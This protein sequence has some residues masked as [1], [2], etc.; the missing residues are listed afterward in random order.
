MRRFLF[1]IAFLVFGLPVGTQLLGSGASLLLAQTS[2]GANTS[3][4]KTPPF[5]PQDDP[6]PG[7][8][9]SLNELAASFEKGRRPLASEMTGNWVEIGNIIDRPVDVPRRLNCTGVTQR[10]KLDFVLVASGY[11]LE[12]H[13]VGMAG[14]QTERM[15]PDNEGSVEFREVYFGGEGTLEDYHCR[16]TRRETLV[17]LIGTFQGVEFKRMS[18]ETNQIFEAKLP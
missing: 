4:E 12:F 8:P 3:S 5:V 14:P 15:K 18:V 10:N 11:S 9:R 17:C 16:L 1:L 13:A 2:G 7:Q 6:C